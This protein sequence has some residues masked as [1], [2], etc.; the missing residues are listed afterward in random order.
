MAASGLLGLSSS[1]ASNP[2]CASV[3]AHP[4]WVLAN[5]FPHRH[6]SQSGAV[7]RHA[8]KLR[9]GEQR[10]RR[11]CDSRHTA[12]GKSHS[13]GDGARVQLT[14]GLGVCPPTGVP[15]DGR[16]SRRGAIGDTSKV[17]PR[18][19]GAP[20]LSWLYDRAEA[21]SGCSVG[22]CDRVDA[23]SMSRRN[24]ADAGRSSSQSAPR[25]AANARSANCQRPVARSARGDRLRCRG[26]AAPLCFPCQR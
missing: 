20:P 5:A 16:R 13:L 3:D 17:A 21:R 11:D 25:V 18:L 6:I 19:F 10:I 2:R 24:R 1:S 4:E 9:A 26:S 22:R 7:G 14:T 15:T 12:G 23:A 8:R